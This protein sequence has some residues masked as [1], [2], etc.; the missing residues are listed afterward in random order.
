MSV[1]GR[2]YPV[3]IGRFRE[4]E[5]PRPLSGD[6]F[7]ERTDATRPFPAG[8]NSWK[9]PFRGQAAEDKAAIRSRGAIFASG[10]PVLG[11]SGH[12][13]WPG[14]SRHPARSGHCRY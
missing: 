7:E 4:S 11:R 10:R 6:E 12:R 14:N 13:P 9:Q 5:F 3:A 2:E 1:E 8:Q